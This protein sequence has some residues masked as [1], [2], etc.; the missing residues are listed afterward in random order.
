VI[1]RYADQFLTR[2]YENVPEPPTAWDDYGG[3]L[4]A[5]AGQGI[6]A[7]PDN[8]RYY[9]DYSGDHLLLNP[10][11]YD[12]V[13]SQNWC[14]FHHHARQI[15]RNYTSYTDWDPLPI[16]IDPEPVNA[17]FFNLGLIKLTYLD[18]LPMIAEEVDDAQEVILLMEAMSGHSITS[19]VA[20]VSAQWYCYSP[21][22][23]RTWSGFIPEGFPFRGSIREQYDYVGADA[24]VRIETTADRMTPGSGS[25]GVAWSAAAKPFGSLEG[26]VRPNRYGLVLPAFTDVRLIPVDAATGGGGGSRPGWSDH[27]RSHLQEYTLQGTAA[28]TPGCWYCQ[29]LLTWESSTFRQAGIAWLDQYSDQCRIPGSRPGDTGG[30][31]RG[32]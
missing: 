17:E 21:D 11:F 15:L 14:W 8:P 1:N 16:V 26:P 32:H 30:A 20:E 10:S 31:R 9:V 12:A 6:A 19:G 2:P 24:A 23:W 5:I 18:S 29:Q 22:R 13:A 7:M 4:I 27:Y 25:R 3:M 28:L